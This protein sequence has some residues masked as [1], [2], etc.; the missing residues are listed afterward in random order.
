MFKAK[1]EVSLNLTLKELDDLELLLS[2]CGV[3]LK[4]EDL[5][6]RCR[7]IN[8]KVKNIRMGLSRQSK[9]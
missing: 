6:G 7:L 1:K 2:F 3:K 9:R 5:K 8:R 4:G